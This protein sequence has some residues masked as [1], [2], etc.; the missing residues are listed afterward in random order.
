MTSAGY[1]DQI[2]PTD[3]EHGKAL[4]MDN[5]MYCP[6]AG[7]TSPTSPTQSYWHYDEW[8]AVK[9]SDQVKSPTTS[10][11]PKPR[12]IPLRNRNAKRSRRRSR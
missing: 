10:A 3:P 12:A 9:S 6:H 2:C 1:M 4:A 11:T 5:G 7:H 8:E